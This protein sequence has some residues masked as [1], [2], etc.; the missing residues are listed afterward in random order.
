MSQQVGYIIGVSGDDL[1]AIARNK[2]AYLHQAKR[3][4]TWYAIAPDAWST[5]KAGAEVNVKKIAESYSNTANPTS[6]YQMKANDGT[7][8]GGKCYP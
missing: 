1:Y 5:A 8:W 6:D 2:C 4:E 3:G 7:V